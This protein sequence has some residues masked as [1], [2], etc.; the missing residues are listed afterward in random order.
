MPGKDWWLRRVGIRDEYCVRRDVAV[1]AEVLAQHAI[2]RLAD[3]AFLDRTVSTKATEVT[4]EVYTH[5]KLKF[6]AE[7]EAD[8]SEHSLELVVWIIDASKGE[9]G[10]NQERRKIDIR[11]K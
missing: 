1:S 10:G 8:Y 5:H 6:F 9:Y 7:R 4:V 11:S 2:V 3:F